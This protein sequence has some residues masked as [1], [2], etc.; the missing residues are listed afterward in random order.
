MDGFRNELLMT[1]TVQRYSRRF[2]GYYEAEVMDSRLRGIVFAIKFTSRG[3]GSRY[4]VSIAEI[5]S[6]K[7]VILG[8]SLL[9]KGN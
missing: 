8:L 4:L 1:A 2:E 3:I 5:F 7:P 9:D 6:K